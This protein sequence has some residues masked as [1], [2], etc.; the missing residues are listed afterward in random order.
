METSLSLLQILQETEESE[1]W[2]RFSELYA[3]LVKSWLKH[4]ISNPQVAD[5]D[6][7]TQEVL[8]SVFQK[9]RSFNWR[10]PGT[11]RAWL[12]AFTWRRAV[13][14]L[15]ARNYHPDGR[16]APNTEL[17]IQQLED[18]S[19]TVSSLFDREHD[20]HLARQMLELARPHFEIQTWKAF[21]LYVVEGKSAP[22]VAEFL[23]LSPNCV[24]IA[25]SRVMRRLRKM[26]EELIG[27]NS[28][29]FQKS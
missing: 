11:F 8:I 17:L 23:G 1:A 12:K 26:A 28:D 20:R 29:F 14:F 3:P 16:R 13:K 7:I 18:P 24:Y 5:L 2:S 4:L 21:E 10:G 22:E 27:A 25:K 19:S 15:S 6:D 9:I